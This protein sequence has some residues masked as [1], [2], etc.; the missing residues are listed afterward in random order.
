MIPLCTYPACGNGV[1]GVGEECDD[2]NSEEGDGCEN[3][4]K[5]TPCTTGT[6]DGTPVE[7]MSYFVMVQRSA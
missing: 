4:C 3:D 5:A 1:Q 2:G 6:A 7:V